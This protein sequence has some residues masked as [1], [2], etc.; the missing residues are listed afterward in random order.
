MSNQYFTDIY[1]RLILGPLDK[2]IDDYTLPY[3]A[4]PLYSTSCRVMGECHNECIPGK[5]ACYL[6]EGFLPPERNHIWKSPDIKRKNKVWKNNTDRN[7][8]YLDLLPTECFYQILLYLD[9]KDF[10]KLKAIRKIYDSTDLP[11]AFWENKIQNVTENNATFRLT[12]DYVFVNSVGHSIIIL[13]DLLLPK[14]L[15]ANLWSYNS[16]V[17]QYI[18]SKCL[19]NDVGIISL[20]ISTKCKPIIK[21]LLK[22][23]VFYGDRLSSNLKMNNIDI[24]NVSELCNLNDKETPLIIGS[25]EDDILKFYLHILS[26]YGFDYHRNNEQ[27]KIMIKKLIQ[28][29]GMTSLHIWM[30]RFNSF[31]HQSYFNYFCDNLFS[32]L[33]KIDEYETF[34][35]YFR[36]YRLSTSA[37]LVFDQIDEMDSYP[38][39]YIKFLEEETGIK[40]KYRDLIVWKANFNQ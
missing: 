4:V 12:L 15:R 40:S 19:S 29:L 26:G 35:K 6:H 23:Y 34:V 2:T 10:S 16:Y 18:G 8:C 17:N 37:E 5:S 27:A 9:I 22:A 25:I 14:I 31:H 39:R 11:K 30:K 32:M 13:F 33:Y 38:Y 20:S 24:S 21:S 1:G 7:I 36:K 3:P 28:K